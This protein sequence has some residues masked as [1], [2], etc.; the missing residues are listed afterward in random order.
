[1]RDDQQ[2]SAAT[3][4]ASLERL[5][6]KQTKLL[7]DISRSLEGVAAVSSNAGLRQLLTEKEAAEHLGVASTTLRFWRYKGDRGIPFVKRGKKVGYY[8]TD[9]DA[10]LNRHV[11]T[12][13]SGYDTRDARS[14]KTSPSV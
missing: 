3:G 9:L 2:R 10:W 7:Q 8:R 6:R 11:F 12:S 4:T 5:I 13:T 14:P 1:M